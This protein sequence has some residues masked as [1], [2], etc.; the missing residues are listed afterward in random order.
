MRSTIFSASP[1]FQKKCWPHFLPPIDQP[2]RGRRLRVSS[3]VGTDRE[4]GDRD[5]QL[6]FQKGD[7]FPQFSG[8]GSPFLRLEEAAASL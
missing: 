7:I 6:L 8:R 2:T 4:K 1:R 5:L 3:P